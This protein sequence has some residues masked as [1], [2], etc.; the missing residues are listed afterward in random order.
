MHNS[1][2]AGI[3]SD[4]IH[5]SPSFSTNNHGFSTVK[6]QP[7]KPKTNDYEELIHKPKING[8]TLIG[9]KTEKEL[10]INI[11][12]DNSQLNNGAGYIKD[13]E[14]EEYPASELAAIWKSKFGS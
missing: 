6:D 5:F 11:P 1:F 3:G 8:V 13:D 2:N 10:K 9:D 12:T 14:L 4:T 7:E